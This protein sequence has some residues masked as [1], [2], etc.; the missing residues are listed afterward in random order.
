VTRKRGRAPRRGPTAALL[1]ALAAAA[2]C[3]GG[4]TPAEPTPASSPAAATG[5]NMRLLARLDLASLTQAVRVQHDEPLLPAGVTSGSGNWGFTHRSGR[6][7]ALTGTSDGLSIVE[8]SDPARARAVAF[9]PGPASSWREVKTF[10]DYVYVTTEAAHGIDIVSLADPDRPRKV[11][12]WRGSVSSAHTLW[13]DAERALLF[14]NG[15]NGRNGG[16]H[17]LDLAD[18]EEPR[19]L[20]VFTGFYVHDSYSRGDV[21][22][23][24]AI[25]DGFLALLDVSEPRRIREINRFF[26]GGRFTHNSWL[27]RDGRFLFTTDERANRPLEGW[28]LLDPMQPRKVTEYL[29]APQT[30]P[31]NVMIDGDRLVVAHYTEGVHLLDVRDPARPRA[32]GSFDTF[33]DSSC[34]SAPFCG[35]WGAYIFPGSNLIVASD[36]TGGLFVLEYTGP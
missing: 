9:V 16:L 10:G 5:T 13:I 2:G 4:N 7:F 15:V 26:T 32:M 25:Y 31:H 11:G 35:V 34:P 36:L 33:T 27:T 3:G 12:T 17:V 8:V 20:G 30:I 6:R 18:P 24:S 14:A 28:D 22:Y 29:A 1:L 19:T 21:L 23:A